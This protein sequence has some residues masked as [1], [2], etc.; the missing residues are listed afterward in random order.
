M[1]TSSPSTPTPAPPQWNDDFEQPGYAWQSLAFYLMFANAVDERLNPDALASAPDPGYHPWD[2]TEPQTAYTVDAPGGAAPG[3]D[4][5]GK[6]D[7]RH[8]NI[9]GGWGGLQQQIDDC[10]TTWNADDGAS[11]PNGLPAPGGCWWAFWLALPLTLT[12]VC[13]ACGQQ[14]SGGF[15]AWLRSGWRTASGIHPQHGWRR[16]RRREIVTLADAADVWGHQATDGMV[17][18]LLGAGGGHPEN[19]GVP[20]Y[21]YRYTT[22]APAGDPYPASYPKWVPV[23]AG[24]VYP[25]VLD[26]DAGDIPGGP[27]QSGDVLGGWV[28]AQIRDGLNNLVVRGAPTTAFLT[29]ACAYRRPVVAVSPTDAYRSTPDDAVGFCTESNCSSGVTTNPDGST[30]QATFA[31]Q[32][33]VPADIPGTG[34]PTVYGSQDL[35]VGIGAYAGAEYVGPAGNSTGGWLAPT[36]GSRA[37]GWSIGKGFWVVGATYSGGT[38]QALSDADGGGPQV[39]QRARTYVVYAGYFGPSVQPKPYYTP[40]PC[41]VSCYDQT[42]FGQPQNTWSPLQTFTAS[43]NSWEVLSG[44]YPS[45]GGPPKMTTVQITDRLGNTG[46]N[47]QTAEG[48][49]TMTTVAAQSLWDGFAFRGGPPA[50]TV[51]TPC[52][53]VP[54]PA[55]N[56]PPTA[57]TPTPTPPVVT[58]C[59]TCA[60]CDVPMG[61][62]G[63]WTPPCPGTLYLMYNDQAG[64]YADNTGQFTVGGSGPGLNSAGGTSVLSKAGPAL[65]A[66]TEAWTVNGGQPLTWQATGTAASSA[67]TAPGYFVGGPNGAGGSTNASAGYLAPGLAAYSLVGVFVPASNGPSGSTG[68]SPSG[69]TTNTPSGSTGNTPSGSTGNTP[70]GSTGN[71]PSGSTGNS[72]GGSGGNASGGTTNTS[73]GGTA[74]GSGGTTGNASG[75]TTGNTSGGSTGNTS[76]GAGNCMSI[77][78]S[79]STVS[80]NADVA[81][82]NGNLTTDGNGSFYFSDPSAVLANGQPFYYAADILFTDATATG[83]GFA[84]A[85]RMAFYSQPGAAGTGL[86]YGYVGGLWFELIVAYG[87]NT[88]HFG[89]GNVTI[90]SDKTCPG[91]PFGH[92]ARVFLSSTLKPAVAGEDDPDDDSDDD[93]TGSVVATVYDVTAGVVIG[94]VTLTPSD[95]GPNY[96]AGYAP[97][98]DPLGGVFG[99]DGGGI[100]SAATVSNVTLC[101]GQSTDPTDPGGPIGEGE[102]P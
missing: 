76:G 87:G 92:L 43:T 82:A 13:D 49:A 71:S 81:Y 8:L 1:N 45:G 72:S 3:Y 29:S 97:G 9:Q 41:V 84:P 2:G 27:Q 19:A 89:T 44:T 50:L 90:A 31:G 63:T 75:G 40:T 25:D 10:S 65:T 99:Q 60:P 64:S 98:S 11:A 7:R 14:L 93:T 86:S 55:P 30:T 22:S 48:G 91:I 39:L 59:S 70:S 85:Y 95:L 77:A 79:A 37:P 67:P 42:L 102:A 73:G 36:T 83:N 56:P 32:A 15:S 34:D 100:Q 23:A 69:S 46:G 54:T 17:A 101:I 20:C 74:N 51:A 12:Y 21:A 4:G 18:R 52:G 94:S 66:A 16:K 24:S 80:G 62:S 38:A 68:N 58:A 33:V 28:F 53:T 96:A 88:C 35:S 6:D 5:V 61:A 57:T 26:S 78:L 47:N